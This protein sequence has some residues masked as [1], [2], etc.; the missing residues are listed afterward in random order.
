MSVPPALIVYLPEAYVVLPVIAG[1]PMSAACCGAGGPVGVGV[2][3]FLMETFDRVAV[4]TT[5][6]A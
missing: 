1:A 2:V 5:P 4:V 6:G 3:L